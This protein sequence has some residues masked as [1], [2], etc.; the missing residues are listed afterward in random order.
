[1]EAYDALISE[2]HPQKIVNIPGISQKREFH[3]KFNFIR[4]S[5]GAFLI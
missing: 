3:F 1:M 2:T 4:F 5:R